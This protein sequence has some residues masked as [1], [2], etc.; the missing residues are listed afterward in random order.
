M[1]N[2]GQTLVTF[3]IILP[4]LLIIL[5]LVID[6]GFLYMEKRNIDNN[7]Y[8]SVEYY[9]NNISDKKIEEKTKKMLNKNI[10]DIDKIIILEKEDYIEINVSKDIKNIYSILKHTEINITY[11]GIKES[12]E[13]I[14]G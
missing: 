12:K 14:K 4:I 8:D 5:A 10:D 1:N 3:I 9:L 2:K 6:L 11:K 13:I 7:V